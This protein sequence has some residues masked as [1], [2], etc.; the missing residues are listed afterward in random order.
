MTV[1]D[2]KLIQVKT[3]PETREETTTITREV[4][5]EIYVATLVAAKGNVKAVRRYA[6]R[7][8]MY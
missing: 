3:N 8:N 7:Q 6:R 1:E 4:A 5:G 2:E